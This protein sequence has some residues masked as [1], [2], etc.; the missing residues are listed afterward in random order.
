MYSSWQVQQQN[1]EHEYSLTLFCHLFP[2]GEFERG[3]KLERES[4][5]IM[6]LSGEK[7]FLEMDMATEREAKIREK[8][9]QNYK[10]CNNPVLVII[11]ESWGRSKERLEKMRGWGEDVKKTALY[12]CL[13]DVQKD[14]L[15]CPWVDC[16]G[17]EVT[18]REI[19]GKKVGEG[20][21]KG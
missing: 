5:G 17:T 11:S 4:D 12:A 10:G 2:E 20:V 15:G 13:E 6:T 3:H 19:V 8:W 7:F 18:L 16:K 21:E 1:A 14:P 9:E